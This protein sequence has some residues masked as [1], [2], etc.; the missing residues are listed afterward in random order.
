MHFAFSHFMLDLL[1][2]T[3]VRFFW[4]ALFHFFC[5]LGKKLWKDIRHWTFYILFWSWLSTDR[6][7][8]SFKFLGISSF[9]S[10]FDSKV[11]ILLSMKR[12]SSVTCSKP[13]KTF[14]FEDHLTSRC[15]SGVSWVHSVGDTST[16]WSVSGTWTTS[17]GHRRSIGIL[18][19]NHPI[20]LI[21]H[22]LLLSHLMRPIN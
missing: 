4:S 17:A 8:R 12:P 16:S 19:F 14:G 11:I 18:L 13:A 20:Q 2:K 5:G 21:T 1:L 22:S 6:F 9:Y 10:S 15:F 3:I 7:R